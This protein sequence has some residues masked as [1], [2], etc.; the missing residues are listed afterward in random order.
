MNHWAHMLQELPT[1]LQQLIA[2]TQ[3]V[4]LP[5]ACSAAE[6]HARL[7][8]A[9]CSAATV[10]ATYATLDPAIQA[11]LQDLRARR[12]GVN[13]DELERLYGPV[14]SITAMRADPIPQTIA[15]RLILLGWL[16]PRLT[17]PR[18]PAHYLLPP[19]LRRRLPSPFQP[20]PL[21][22]APPAPPPPALHTVALLIHKPHLLH[23]QVAKA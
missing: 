18:H 8:A 7:R 22:A 12:G 11:A 23:A 2:R 4:S 1:G 19:E 16:L 17:K 3:R 21:G 5:R 9:L 15:E 13:P 6:R 14:R 20:A 10:R